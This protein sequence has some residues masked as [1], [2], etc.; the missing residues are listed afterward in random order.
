[1]QVRVDIVVA[2]VIAM[3]RDA[4]TPHLVILALVYLHK[5]P[6]HRPYRAH[7]CVGSVVRPTMSMRYGEANG[8]TKR[9]VA[10][11]TAHANGHMM[12]HVHCSHAKY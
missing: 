6:D 5:Q 12:V 4:P 3:L 2:G 7:L 1:M 8:H 10:V 9:S 11:R